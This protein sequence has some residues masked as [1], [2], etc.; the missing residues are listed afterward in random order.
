MSLTLWVSQPRLGVSVELAAGV[1]D[2]DALRRRHDE[3][4]GNSNR[5]RIAQKLVEASNIS[6]R[7]QHFY[8]SVFFLLNLSRTENRFILSPEGERRIPSYRPLRGQPFPLYFSS[9]L[10]NV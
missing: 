7:L 2:I 10:L 6:F 4:H 9:Q 1:E 8:L 5:Q 3:G